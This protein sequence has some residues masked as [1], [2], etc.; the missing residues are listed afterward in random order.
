MH[1]GVD[2]RSRAAFA[3][4]AVIERGDHLILAVDAGID[5]GQGAEPVEPEHGKAAFSQRAEIAAGAFD[6][7]QFDRRTGDRI[8]SG[9]LR[10]SVAAGVVGVA[11]ICPDPVAALDQLAHWVRGCGRL[12]RLARWHQPLAQL[13]CVPPIRLATIFSW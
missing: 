13:A 1:R 4:Q 3:V 7:E 12:L 10:R 5:I 8:G 2:G 6:P 9:P 11:G